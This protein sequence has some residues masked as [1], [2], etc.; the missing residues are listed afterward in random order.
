MNRWFPVAAV[1][2]CSGL[3]A[4]ACVTKP[5]KPE[6]AEIQEDP[7]VEVMPVAS[8]VLVEQGNYYGRLA[9]LS[10]VTVSAEVAGKVLEVAVDKGSVVEPGAVLFAVDEEPFRFA[11]AQAEKNL[12]MATARAEQ[13]EYAIAMESRQLNSGLEQAQAAV[14]M[15]Q[16]RLRIVEKGARPEEVKQV[17]AAAQAAQAALDNAT[18][19]RDR[20]QKL[21]DNGAATQQQLDGAISLLQGA[22]ARYEQARQIH[23]LA[24]NGAREE[25][26]DSARAGVAQASAALDGAAAGL[27]ALDVRRKELEVI[28]TQIE[29]ARLSVETARYNRAKARVSSPLDSTGVVAQRFID[30]GEMVAPGA[31]AFE[32]LDVSRVKLV[33][34]VPGTDIWFI[35]E[36][37]KVT[38][39]CTGDSRREGIV[40]YVGLKA[41]SN[42][43]TFPVE[44]ELS[45][46]DGALRSGLVCEAFPALRSHT[47][48]L[49]PRQVVLDTE[50][51]KVVMVAEGDIVRERPVKL[52]A[53][54]G[55]VAAIVEGLSPGDNVVVV[56]ERQ[57]RD[58]ESI[59]IHRV[60]DSIV[61]LSGTEI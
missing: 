60:H 54:R 58:G 44:I 31:P 9:P 8:G 5:D 39:E 42:N 6:R 29:S 19:E 43:A 2:I 59:V 37:Q 24:V 7:S 48:L 25:D 27:S 46:E 22:T 40:T 26:K 1:V 17:K 33:I 35:K 23:R 52:S 10:S 50:E 55:G 18:L 41:D 32:L 36:R 20:I 4:G 47:A 30:K 28:G 3:L 11:E 53:V 51:G 12:A 16:A 21:F 15:A 45:N 61:S 13:L 34:Q 14:A 38:V 57:V 56:G 49:V